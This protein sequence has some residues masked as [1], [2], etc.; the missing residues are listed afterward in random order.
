VSERLLACAL[1]RQGF[2]D[3]AVEMCSDAADALAPTDATPV[4]S[5]SVRGR[6]G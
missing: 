6:C 4:E 5:W 1:I 3:E 2:L